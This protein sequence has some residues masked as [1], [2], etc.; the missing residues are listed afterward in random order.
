MAVTNN[1]GHTI[2]VKHEKNSS[3]HPLP[4]GETWPHNQDGFCDP[5]RPGEVF[6]TVD[7]VDATLN[8]D[9]TVTLSIRGKFFLMVES[10]MPD[11]IKSAIEKLANR[12][13]DNSGWYGREYINEHSDWEDL[14][15]S[16]FYD[17]ENQ[18]CIDPKCVK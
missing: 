7:G 14:F 3:V 12:K 5:N 15:Q 13:F 11:F 2:Y 6:K 10:I 8:E 17:E 4:A 18:M 16:S 9:E 1:T